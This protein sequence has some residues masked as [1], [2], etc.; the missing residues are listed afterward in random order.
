[1][2]LLLVFVIGAFIG[3]IS[4]LALAAWLEAHR[5]HPYNLSASDGETPSTDSSQILS[6][7]QV[8]KIRTGG[9]AM[10]SRG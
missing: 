10:H 9:A 4:W 8:Q 3:S 7:H 2:I 5:E 6:A 1:M